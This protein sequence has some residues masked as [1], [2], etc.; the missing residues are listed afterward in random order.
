[1]DERNKENYSYHRPIWDDNG[2]YHYEVLSQPKEKNHVA[3]LIKPPEKVIPVI[4]I[5]G[6]MGSN[7]KNQKSEVWQFSAS[8]L[9][10]W[11]PAGPLQLLPGRA[12]GPGWLKIE[13]SNTRLSLP[14]DDPY[15]EIYLNKTAWWRLCEQNLLLGDTD[16]EWAAFAY[17][18]KNPVRKFIEELNGKYHPQTWLFYGASAHNPSDAFLTWKER[19]PLRVQEAQR[20]RRNAGDPVELSPLRASALISSASPGDGTVPVTAIRT[21]SPCIKGVLATDVDHEGAYAV[22]PVDR[23]RS[24]YRDLSDALVFTVRSV[25]K[26][27]Q[28]VPAP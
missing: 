24:V 28:Q 14:T 18:I 5:P 7:L 3:I 20:I 21:T 12:Y 9:K 2:R 1:M 8:S 15:K 17:R 19:I 6:G 23:S 22:N 4:F 27:V 25:M 11:V 26:I 16:K 10:K 13:G